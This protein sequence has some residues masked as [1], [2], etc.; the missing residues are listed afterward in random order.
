MGR[1]QT[2]M[3][4]SLP[5][6]R[7]A[8]IEARY[9][10]LR[11]DVESLAGL[12]QMVGKA[13]MDIAASLHIK[14]PSVSRIERQTDMYLSTLLGY[15]Q[16]IGGK[17]E[18][19]VHLPGCPPLRLSGLGV[20]PAAPFRRRTDPMACSN[21]SEVSC[22]TLMPEQEP[23]PARSPETEPT[24]GVVFDDVASCRG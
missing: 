1:T 2:E 10:D 6:E 4:D 20:I 12:R 23:A 11:A 17:L 7:R 14:Q 5:P 15:I 8:G 22:P 19:L 18:L 9:N 3:L 13:Q 16:A 21:Q 24:R